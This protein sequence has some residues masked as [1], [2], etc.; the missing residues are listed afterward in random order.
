LPRDDLRERSLGLVNAAELTE[1]P[2]GASLELER[3]HCANS[4]V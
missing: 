2:E 1:N 3:V 4:Q